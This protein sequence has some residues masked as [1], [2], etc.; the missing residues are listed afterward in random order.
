MKK[1][2]N[3]SRSFPREI[4]T[5]ELVTANS[6]NAP[7]SLRLIHQ[8]AIPAGQS[9]R[10]NR[11]STGMQQSAGYPV[12]FSGTVGYFTPSAPEKKSGDTAVLMVSAWGFEEMSSRRFLRTLSEKLSDFG[13]PSLRFDYPGT[14]DSLEI[15]DF[16]KGLSIWD[17][18][19]LTAA[20]RV[21][22][23]SNCSR[24]IVIGQSL[25]AAMTIRLAPELEN[26]DA[27]VLLAP[28]LSGKH[29]LRETA[30][31]SRT[32]DNSLQLAESLR[33]THPGTIAGL[34]LPAE[35][36]EDVRKLSFSNL[37][38]RPADNCLILVPRERPQDTDF[39]NQMRE[40]G[41]E[42]EVGT[43]TGYDQMISNVTYSKVPLEPVEKIAEWVQSFKVK[44]QSRLVSHSVEPPTPIIGPH[45]IETPV[46]FGENNRLAGI[47]SEPLGLRRGSTVLLMTTAYERHAS[48]G[49]MNVT[50]A[51]ELAK[52]GIVS[53]RFDTANVADSPPRSGFPEEVI[54]TDEQQD[55]VR[56]ALDF[57][58]RNNMSSVVA[59]GRC[60]GAY[61]AFQS[62]IHHSRVKSIVAV[63]PYVFYWRK[64]D[65]VEE[66]LKF[67]PKELSSYAT[68]LFKAETIRRI[69]NGQ[70]NLK[71]A[72]LNISR[73][74]FTKL[75]KLTG[76]LFD[77]LPGIKSQKRII[78]TW[79]DTLHER[80]T[81]L[82]L[83]YSE[84]D[85]GLQYFYEHF[86]T[87]GSGIKP[88]PNV[89][90]TIVKN[91]DHNLTPPHAREIYLQAI[92]D[93][94]LKG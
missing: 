23:L 89:T 64:G 39:A 19:I 60:S 10:Q 41:C 24:L 90:Y 56:Q 31:W 17:N 86:G 58:E 51:R 3:A 20:E 81:P 18:C 32:I 5:P 66:F 61:L 43:F 14:G 83:I 46:R 15:N 2:M 70:I 74:G 36:V 26:M 71:A 40:L 72:V 7:S 48:W 92:K 77:S 1:N 59:A 28:V 54:Y 8:I 84:N 57:L 12:T 13:I 78:K 55:D 94:A 73:V 21:K 4:R 76:P 49:R 47:L 68:L 22:Q 42:V 33:D 91:A 87:D 6:G 53:L 27:M 34:R 67:V 37:N 52:V 80:K 82:K 29:F 30:V 85:Q 38:K 79:F 9:Y 16:S 63:N 45:F 75:L 11:N 88:Y 65:S 35:I 69:F 25:G 93:A 62:A 44:S 50:L